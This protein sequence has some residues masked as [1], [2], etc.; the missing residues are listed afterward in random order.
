M[1]NVDAF[2]NN[3][4]GLVDMWFGMP[5]EHTGTLLRNHTKV[6]KICVIAPCLLYGTNGCVVYNPIRSTNKVF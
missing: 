3:L 1:E 2:S 4:F 6:G 5:N